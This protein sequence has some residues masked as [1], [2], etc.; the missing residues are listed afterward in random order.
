MLL[1]LVPDWEFPTDKPE[2]RKVALLVGVKKYKKEELS[3]LRFPENDVVE[4]AALLRQGGYQPVIVLTQT[5]GSQSPDLLPT[6]DNIREALTGLL[7]SLRPDDT[8][9][10]AF[11]GHGV[12]FKEDADHYFCP[13]DARLADRSTL[14]SLSALYARLK[15]S[16]GGVRVLLVDA[17][18]VNPEPQGRKF[19]VTVERQADHLIDPPGGLA[20]LYSCSRGEASYEDDGL[21]HGVFFHYVLEGLRGRAANRRGAVTVESLAAYVKVEVDNHVKGQLNP[22]AR[23]TPHLRG[24][25]R[26]NV[27][28][29]NGV[30]P[31]ELREDWAEFRKAEDLRRGESFLRERAGVRLAAWR[32]GADG[33][34]AAAQCLYGECLLGGVGVA[35]DEPAAA[36]WFRRAAAQSHAG[37]QHNLGVCYSLGLGVTRDEGEAVRWFRRAAAANF[38]PA[39]YALGGCYEKGRGVAKDTAEALRWYQRAA[40]Q[41][42]PAALN[43]LGWCYLEG[44]G[45]EKDPA[46]AVA[47]FRRTAEKDYPP[48]L[49]LLGRCYLEGLG[50]EKDEREAFRAFRRAAEQQDPA[51]QF[52]LGHC[53]EHGIGEPQDLSEALRWYR[54]AA[55]QGHEQAL[56]ALKRLSP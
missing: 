27:P 21:Q 10:L 54:K 26:G 48:G 53:Y 13:M 50:V 33:G 2:G 42:H 20:A 47:Y 55:E 28:L 49:L 56:A 30:A 25:L 36:V 14:V 19:A 52:L 1:T 6:G 44:I 22:L 40:E 38:A 31:F 34:L 24:D 39:Q 8:A 9:L 5:A 4:L 29:L 43:Q 41:D 35:K 15:E 46:R 12:Q 16:P 11:S 7:S 23:Q 45:V 51:A 32:E 37:G 18:R 17:C 3:D